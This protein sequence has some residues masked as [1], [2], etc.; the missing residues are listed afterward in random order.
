MSIEVCWRLS[1]MRITDGEDAGSGYAKSTFSQFRKFDDARFFLILLT[2]SQWGIAV[3][4]AVS[5]DGL[6]RQKKELL[7]TRINSDL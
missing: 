5:V 4:L 3:G 1:A 7:K 2:S 6:A